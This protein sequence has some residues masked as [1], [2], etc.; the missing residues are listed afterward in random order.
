M[1]TALDTFI[2]VVVRR[3]V[4]VELITPKLLLLFSLNLSEVSVKSD[5][6]LEKSN[7]KITI[8]VVLAL[9]DKSIDT[10]T[11]YDVHV[12]TALKL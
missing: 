8:H 7:K 1:C 3:V 5:L 9:S 12:M 11:F 2:V 6:D 10:R 4:G